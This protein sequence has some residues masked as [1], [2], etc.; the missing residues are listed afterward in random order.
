MHFRVVDPIVMQIFS[1]AIVEEQQKH[2]NTSSNNSEVKTEPENVQQNIIQR[3]SFTN[4][5]PKA[6]STAPIFST[7]EN[8]SLNLA[9]SNGLKVRIVSNIPISL[10]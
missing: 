7:P 2:T 10:F 1:D 8:R 9:Y 6:A 3:H 4:A 5:I